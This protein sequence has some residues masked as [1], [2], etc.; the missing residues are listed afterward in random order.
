MVAE[1][2]EAAGA[3]PA[4]EV[5]GAAVPASP[6]E[7]TATMSR[8]EFTAATYSADVKEVKNISRSEYYSFTATVRFRATIA[9]LA[10]AARAAL[11]KAA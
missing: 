7:A 8:I 9:C 5:V 2:A 6:L 11:Q 3:P 1:A 4:T 10:N